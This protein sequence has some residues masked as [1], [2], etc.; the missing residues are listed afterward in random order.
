MSKNREHHPATTDAI[1]ADQLY[2]LEQFKRVSGL[3]VHALRVARRSGLTV[4]RCGGRGYVLGRD[5]IEFLEAK[6]N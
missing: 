3:G 2:T 1:S 6:A 5:F 4:K